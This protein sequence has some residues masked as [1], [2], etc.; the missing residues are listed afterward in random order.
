MPTARSLAP[1]A[2]P[3]AL[4]AAVSSAHATKGYFSHGYGTK[5]RGQAGVGVAWS[6]DAL[7]AAA[8]PAGTLAVGERVDLG[9]SWFAPRRNASVV[10]NALGADAN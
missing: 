4:L 7:G 1:R 2:L 5:A 9:L 3:V 10:G 6:Q 8:N